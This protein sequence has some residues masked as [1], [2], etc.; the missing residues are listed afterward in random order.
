MKTV[1]KIE[2]FVHKIEEKKIG[3]FICFVFS[4]VSE[5]FSTI[6]S[7]KSKRLFLRGVGVCI[8]LT[9]I[10]PKIISNSQESTSGRPTETL[11]LMSVD[12]Y[13]DKI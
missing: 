9:T 12:L 13:T 8:S 2:K 6:R 4:F 11:Y 10:G 1:N 7:K 5:R 3:K